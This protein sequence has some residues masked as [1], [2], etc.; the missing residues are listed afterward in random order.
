M[1]K[2]R[3]QREFFPGVT[4]ALLL[5]LAGCGSGDDGADGDS[6]GSGGSSSGG[7]SGTGG[8]SGSSGS[9][10]SGTGGGGQPGTPSGRILWTISSFLP[11]LRGIDTG[12]HELV[13]DVDI[14]DLDES[15]VGINTLEISDDQ[16]WLGRDDS[17]LTVVDR[18]TEA[19]VA[20]I[21]LL[22]FGENETVDIY[23]IAVG[24]G[25]AFTSPESN[26][27][28]P[29]LRID[30]STFEVVTQADILD[31]VGY[32]TRILYDGSDLWIMQWNAIELVRADPTTLD[33]RERVLLGQDPNDPNGA[34]GPF[35][36][37]G[38]MA[39]SGDTLWIIDTESLRLLS[40]DKATVTPRAVADLSDLTDF[41]TFFEFD[42][43]SHGVFLLLAEPGIVVRFDPETGERLNTYDFADDGG[44]GNMAVGR[45][46]LYV[47]PGGSEFVYDTREVDIDS[48][49][50][51]QTITSDVAIN[52]IA[53]Q[54]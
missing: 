36:G 4:V 10:G 7:T 6:G 37:V 47:T 39:D 43:N 2:F 30:A 31:G 35:Y 12:S 46:T 28:P 51:L 44:V 42:A 48:G 38:Y 14:V 52:G 29:I 49:R 17:V 53:A 22:P 5:T 27:Q 24:G 11:S 13:V 8:S 41:D 21:D 15:D 23:N 3:L 16:V 25:Y 26:I 20:E 18:G 50:V 32:P 9:S 1:A 34:F 45:D 33:V 54:K 19:I 40:V